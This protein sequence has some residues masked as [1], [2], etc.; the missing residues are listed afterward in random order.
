MISFQ[1]FLNVKLRCVVSAA[2]LNNQYFLGKHERHIHTKQKR[3]SIEL[4][5]IV[6]GS[7]GAFGHYVND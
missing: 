7:G 1:V 6:L 5:S 2:I 4:F 3:V